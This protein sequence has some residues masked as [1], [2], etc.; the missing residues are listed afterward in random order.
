[1]KTIRL[2]KIVAVGLVLSLLAT[3]A[4][5]DDKAKLERK[6]KA[7]LALAATKADKPGFVNLAPVPRVIP[8][9]MPPAKCACGAGC[10]CPEGAC[11]LNCPAETKAAKPEAKPPAGKTLV[12]VGWQWQQ[13]CDGG[14]CRFVQVPVYEYR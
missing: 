12:H 6:A 11:P 8:E 7:A 4:K 5:A 10:K 3:E 14:A 9:P 2:W 13:V 1:M